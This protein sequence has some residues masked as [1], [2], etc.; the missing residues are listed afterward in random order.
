MNKS[1][2]AESRKDYVASN[3]R[4]INNDDLKVGS[5]M[6]IADALE[7]IAKILNCRNTK[8]AARAIV[9]MDKRMAKRTP[10]R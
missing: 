1:F 3:G 8:E 5:L 4:G 7:D 2:K 10:L 6:R 9:R